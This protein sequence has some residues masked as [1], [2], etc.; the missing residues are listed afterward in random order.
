ME[1]G[2]HVLQLVAVRMLVAHCDPPDS[3]RRFDSLRLSGGGARFA[4]PTSPIHHTVLVNHLN[5]QLPLGCAVRSALIR[6]KRYDHLEGLSNGR[7]DR[8]CRHS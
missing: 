3:F 5:Y 1:S 6:G 8:A 2:A 4:N 7:I